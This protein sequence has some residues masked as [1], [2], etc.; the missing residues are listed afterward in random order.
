M[1][2]LKKEAELRKD[3]K[4]L[5]ERELHF[6]EW[7]DS[8]DIREH[9]NP[10]HFYDYKAAYEA[11]EERDMVTGKFSSKY[12]HDL[13]PE[14]FEATENGWYDTKYEKYVDRT[15]VMVQ[16]WERNEYLADIMNSI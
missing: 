10:M 2:D 4:V 11:D 8:N 16:E 13:S 9:N 15:D 14:R 7:L 6:Q 1:A 12:K 3:Q 5:D